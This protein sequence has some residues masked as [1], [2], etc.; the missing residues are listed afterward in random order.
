[1][2][3]ILSALLLAVLCALSLTSAV[4]ADVAPP[5]QPPGFNPEPGNEITQVRMLAEIVTID[6]LAVDPPQAHFSAIFTMRNL[7]GST[8][9]MAVRFPLAVN[10]GFFN[11]VEIKNVVIKVNEQTTGYERIQGP[12]PIYGFEE[13]SAPWAEFDV[14]FPPGEDVTIS[15]FYDLDGTGY[16]S[17]TCTSFNYILSTGAGWKGTIGTGEIILRLP[18]D[19]NPQNVIL[20]EYQ[21][22]PRFSGREARWSFKELE[23][24]PADNLTFEIVKP[25][26]W[27]QVGIELEN[28]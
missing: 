7:S 26:I 4:S 13:E 9:A 17:E 20:N 18:Y 21:S 8:E 12:E 22:P 10:D 2:R 23:P 14:N 24:T 5:Q 3:R 19:A 6:V 15:V 16:E 27:K 11:L 25:I 1:M 28:I